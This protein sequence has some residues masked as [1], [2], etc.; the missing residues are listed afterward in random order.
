MSA[1][2][3]RVKQKLKSAIL[4]LGKEGTRFFYVEVGKNV[5]RLDYSIRKVVYC[6]RIYGSNL[7]VQVLQ[8]YL[9]LI[10]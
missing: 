5:F 1:E 8:Y 2:N 9:S 3:Q 6:L 7:S 4:S 10:S